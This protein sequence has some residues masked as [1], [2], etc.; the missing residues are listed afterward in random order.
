M[1][2]QVIAVVLFDLNRE[3]ITVALLLS[4]L[5][6]PKYTAVEEEEDEE[7]HRKHS[8]RTTQQHNRRWW[9]FSQLHSPCWAEKVFS[10]QNLCDWPAAGIS[11]VSVVVRCCP[12]PIT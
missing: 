8:S 9:S 7:A 3:L 4:I 1:L 5:L 11:L 2:R 12:S 10:S 6:R